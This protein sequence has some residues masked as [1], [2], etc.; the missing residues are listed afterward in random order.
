MKTALVLAMKILCLFSS[1]VASYFQEDSPLSYG[2]TLFHM[3][4]EECH[5]IVPFH[6]VSLP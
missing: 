6:Y 1:P 2:V 3:L 4:L 5:L